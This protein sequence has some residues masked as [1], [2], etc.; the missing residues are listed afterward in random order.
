MKQLPVVCALQY[1]HGHSRQGGGN[2]I[3]TI[4]IKLKQLK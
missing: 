4:K 3:K 1:G 2:K